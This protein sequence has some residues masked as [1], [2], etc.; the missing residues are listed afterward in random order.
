MIIRD[1]PEDFDGRWKIVLFDVDESGA[2][3][4]E[5]KKPDTFDDVQLSYIQRHKE[6]LRLKEALSSGKISPLALHLELNRMTV[7]ELAARASVRRGTVRKHLTPTGFDA[8]TVEQ[9]RRYARVFDVSVADFFGYL[10]V[11]EKIEATVTDHQGH[12]VQIVDLR[13]KG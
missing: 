7:E 3:R 12:L 4:G 8:V 9:L 1:R 11:Q 2:L 10:Q 6:L 13:V 5:L